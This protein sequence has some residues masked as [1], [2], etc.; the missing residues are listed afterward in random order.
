MDLIYQ[1]LRFLSREKF[2]NYFY[3]RILC[4][5]TE[6]LIQTSSK[7]LGRETVSKFLR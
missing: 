2:A 6:P 4:I 7:N 1:K 3:P 5:E